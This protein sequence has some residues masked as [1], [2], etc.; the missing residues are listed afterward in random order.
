[1]TEPKPS[2]MKPC[3]FC[4]GPGAHVHQRWANRD[5]HG[6]IC[7]GDCGTFFDCRE[8]TEGRAVDAW[9]RRSEPA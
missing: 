5:F 7:E 8:A 4:G 9:N 1:M 3:P 6:V 2:T